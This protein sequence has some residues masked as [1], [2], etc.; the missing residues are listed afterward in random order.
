MVGGNAACNIMGWV[1][2]KTASDGSR[3]LFLPAS[4]G[5][6]FSFQFMMLYDAILFA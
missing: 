6:V 3:A 5:Q 1:G 4:T 2:R